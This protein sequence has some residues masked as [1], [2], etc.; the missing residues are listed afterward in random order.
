MNCPKIPD[1]LVHHWWE[2][3]NKYVDRDDPMSYFRAIARFA[4]KWGWCQHIRKARDAADTELTDCCR[5]LATR[6]AQGYS[7]KELETAPRPASPTLRE[8]AL[9]GLR[10]QQIAT[11]DD[12][13][14]I[15]SGNLFGLTLAA[16]QE[17]SE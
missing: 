9:A 6:I 11:T 10:S 3:A 15:I 8:Q 12:G 2:S 4:S 7:A 16:L 1:D 5:E 17:D 14:V 13:S